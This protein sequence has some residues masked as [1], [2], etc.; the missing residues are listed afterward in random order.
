MAEWLDLQTIALVVGVLALVGWYF[1]HV[2]T[3]MIKSTKT[4]NAYLDGRAERQRHEL[5][6]EAK[7]GPYPF[8]Y[9]AAQKLVLAMLCAGV[10]FSMLKLVQG[11]SS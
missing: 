9:K 6:R 1:W 4:I 10:A 3:S 8:W 5:E 7:F 2:A 11:A